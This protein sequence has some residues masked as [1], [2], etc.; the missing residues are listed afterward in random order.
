MGRYQYISRHI[1]AYQHEYK[2]LIGGKM[3][4]A[5]LP[6]EIPRVNYQD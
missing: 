3:T 2:L 1:E 5:Q 6:D 4:V